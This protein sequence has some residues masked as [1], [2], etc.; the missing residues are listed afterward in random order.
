MRGINQAAQFLS[1]YFHEDWPT[2]AESDAGIM[3]LFMASGVSLQV[4]VVIAA[5]LQSITVDIERAYRMTNG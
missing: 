4:T 2:E 5:Q 3:D 1:A